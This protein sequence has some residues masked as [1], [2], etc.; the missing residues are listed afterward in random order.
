[1]D[2]LCLGKA[3]I[4]RNCG[5]RKW[6]HAA[7]VKLQMSR[8][9]DTRFFQPE[10]KAESINR[11][12]G[13]NQFILLAVASHA[14]ATQRAV[15]QGCTAPEARCQCLPL[16]KHERKCSPPTSPS[17]GW[18][19]IACCATQ[20]TSSSWRNLMSDLKKAWKWRAEASAGLHQGRARLLLQRSWPCGCHQSNSPTPH[21][22]YLQNAKLQNQMTWTILF[23]KR[24]A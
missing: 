1:M 8:A 24:E 7:A 3:E 10:K 22:R 16:V 9:S 2:Q 6:K 12:Q 5:V 15:A 18:G 14:W 17:S 21:P 23:A 4:S 20:K 13:M 11:P 19:L